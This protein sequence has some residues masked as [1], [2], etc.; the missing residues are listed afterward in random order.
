MDIKETLTTKLVA[1]DNNAPQRSETG[2]IQGRGHA[3]RDIDFTQGQAALVATGKFFKHG[4]KLMDP[5]NT[6]ASK[7]EA[8]E[9]Q[10]NLCRILLEMV[11]PQK[12]P[13]QPVK[14]PLSLLDIWWPGHIATLIPAIEE[15]GFHR[16]WATEH[17]SR[18]QSASPTLIATLAAGCSQ[19]LRVGTAGILLRYASPL[20]VAADFAVLELF[21]PGRVDLGFA[22]AE[23]DARYHQQYAADLSSA[24]GKAYHARVRRLVALIR[25]E[26]TDEAGAVRPGPR[27]NGTPQL[28]LCGT[29]PRS[30]QLAGELGLRY[31][32]HHHLAQLR[33]VRSTPAE[34]A[35]AYRD[36]FVPHADLGEPYLAIAAYG[37]CAA[38][39]AAA[40][41]EWPSGT[42][43][44]ARPSFVGNGPECAEQLAGLVT[45][46][47]ADELFIDCFTKS[48][49]TRITALRAI[50]AE[51]SRL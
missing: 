22:G 46:Y 20:R 50:A 6:A 42:E 26:N 25:D 1:Q 15:L 8:T 14:I 24:D 18:H 21:F 19:T 4:L 36:A 44:E 16:Y 35:A 2:D 38:D 3:K 17:Y 43:C 34:A 33:E 27:S 13:Q 45:A 7:H 28:W 29:G 11:A 51:W 5:S 31:A 37:V 39:R 9:H 49:E 23:I 41:R 30:A 32:Y 48:I 47:G 12:H 10:A 40:E